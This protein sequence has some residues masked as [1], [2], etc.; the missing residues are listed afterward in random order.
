ME[1]V[2][3]IRAFKFN[4]GGDRAHWEEAHAPKRWFRGHD[5]RHVYHL[6]G[7]LPGGGFEHVTVLELSEDFVLIRRIDARA[8][9]PSGD[10]WELEDVVDRTFAADG[11]LHV[12]EAQ[13]RSYRFDEPPDAF[14][15]LPEARPRCAGE[16]W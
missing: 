4:K 7:A 16:S 6:R 13:R 11:S 10:A 8:M 15:V 12:E 9:R 1:R 2:E 14:A 3:Q 5:G